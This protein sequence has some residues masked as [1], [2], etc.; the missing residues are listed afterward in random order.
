MN[1]CTHTY[2]HSH[3]K[4]H[5]IWETVRIHCLAFCQYITEAS[6]SWIFPFSSSCINSILSY[7]IGCPKITNLAWSEKCLT[8]IGC[9]LSH[10]LSCVCVCVVS[11][12]VIII[13]SHKLNFLLESDATQI[14][15]IAS[16]SRIYT[17]TYIHT[18]REYYIYIYAP[19]KWSF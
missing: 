9:S 3:T 7:R 4:M 15:Q 5:L 19:F 8:R 1:I 10:S 13:K 6:E 11:L 16:S 12:F 14:G 2:T 18:Q 17:Y